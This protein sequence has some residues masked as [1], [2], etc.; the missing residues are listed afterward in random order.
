MIS[1]DSAKAMFY[2]VCTPVISVLCRAGFV[3]GQQWSERL[4]LRSTAG[5]APVDMQMS[6]GE[7]TQL[8][9][10]SKLEKG[11]MHSHAVHMDVHAC[12][13]W[14]VSSHRVSLHLA[15]KLS[16]HVPQAPAAVQAV[17]HMDASPPPGLPGAGPPDSAAPFSDQL[18]YRDAQITKLA[19]ERGDSAPS[20]EL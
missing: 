13:G 6:A 17:P 15:T 9:H 1:S 10:C 20:S 16:L 18:R 12:F 11:P 3:S 8:A 5:E 19:G 14:S 7:T 2:S 4:A